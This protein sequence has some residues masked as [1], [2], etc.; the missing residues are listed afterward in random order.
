MD[1]YT[2]EHD[3]VEAIRRFFREHGKALIGGALIG[4]AILFGWQAW[5]E[6]RQRAAEAASAEYAALMNALAKGQTEAALDHGG[7]LLGQ[8][9]DTAFGPL[10]ALAL[11][12]IKLEQGDPAS[13]R[14]HLKWVID[15]ARR[16]EVVHVGRLRL[17][18]IL[19]STQAAEEALML[20]NEVEPGAFLADY[21]ELKGDAQ[22]ALGRKDEA[23]KSYQAA[24]AALPETGRA[25]RAQ[26]RLKLDDLGAAAPEAAG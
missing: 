6:S 18:K 7:R 11:A 2:T 17:A 14:A 10:A 26:L 22:F 23:I 8:S 20:L 4:L 13:A 5:Q 25:R 16:E 24:L 19:I 15:N 9:G 12:K 1:V 21:A 3:Q